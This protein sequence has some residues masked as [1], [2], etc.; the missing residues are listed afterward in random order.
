M[1]K[2]IITALLLSAACAGIAAQEAPLLLNDEN[3]P[4]IVRALTLE[5]KAELVVGAGF[6]SLFSRAMGEKGVLVPGAAGETRP[7]GRLGIPAIVLSDG[8]AG[9]RIEPL[10]KREKGKSFYA[11]AF[12]TGTI[13]AS[14][15]NEET[16]RKVGAA[17][18]N[19]ALEYGVDVLLAPGM[20]LH[21]N[22]LNGRN[23]EYYSEDPVLSGKMAAAL[24]RGVQ[25]QG[26]GTSAKHYAANSQ[27]THRTGNDARIDV[28]TLRE[29]YLK[30]FEIAVREAAPWTVMSSYNK[31]NGEYTQS[32][33]WLLT[34]VLRNEWGFEGLVMTDWTGQRETDRQVAAGND[35]M[36]PGV[37]GQ[38]REIVRKV[39]ND[40]LPE[41]LLDI[42]VT[43]VLELIVKT[44]RFREYPYSDSPDFAA[45]AKVAREA[46]ADGIVLL[47]ND[48][49]LPL[50]PQIKTVALYGVAAYHPCIGG[51]GSGFVHAPYAV[52]VPEALE[53]AGMRIDGRLG[54]IYSDYVA[55]H[56]KSGI[57][58]EMTGTGLP[59]EFSVT[60][61]IRPDEADV[62]LFVI[63][64]QAGEEKDRELEDDFL[65][66]A[67]ER[68]NLTAVADAF[69]AAGKKV[70]VVL[71]IGGV[72]ETASWKGLADALAVTWQPG[73]EG[74]H[75]LVEVLT[76]QVNPSGKL[77]MTF[78][79]DYLD[80]PSSANF[81]YDV[82]DRGSRNPFAKAR[83]KG[84]RNVDFTEY[85][86]GLN[87]GYRYFVGRP[88]SFPFGFG[89]S[90]TQFS[91]D[92]ISVTQAPDGALTA[93]ITVTNT[94]DRSG[95]EIVQL[96][97][98][99]RKPAAWK[100]ERELKGFAKTRC[101]APGESETVEIW[102]APYVLAS[103]IEG[104]WALPEEFTLEAGASVEDIRLHADL[105]AET[106]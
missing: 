54:G 74:A 102:I 76:G 88:V 41:E 100:P 99:D 93:R 85:A 78:P 75:A 95:R 80:I 103:Y 59:A 8:P 101:L 3:I 65:L 67:T 7:V 27:E 46:A 89:L 15:W 5:E 77:P 84:R 90:Y 34:G 68:E 81:P 26:V 50:D 14:T 57:V 18:G 17:M 71:N 4:E 51:T 106:D 60:G 32:D 22:P 104:K 23:F 49:V 30:G 105:P 35:L 48:G 87:V 29:L 1:K 19:E 64:R 94:G 33:A 42:C 25:S 86:E 38:I 39:K 31:I 20:N 47:K 6:K 44:P 12:P 21:R 61:E 13:L 91:Y 2:L 58:S 66:T 69:H 24:I 97:V 11:T 55:R 98:H 40:E 79:N 82:P 73:E 83:D 16:V 56:R 72:I 92:N 70:V 37:K 9:V 45:H 36:E 96:Y 28:R 10:R 62:A 53:A 43:R 63:G 52:T